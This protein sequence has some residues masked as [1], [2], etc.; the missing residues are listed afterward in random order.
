MGRYDLIRTEFL[1]HAQ[2]L[3]AWA[4]E[5]EDDNKTIK[6]VSRGG[7]NAVGDVRKCYT[8]GKTGLMARE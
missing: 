4:Q 7:Y 5:I 6:S 8:C 3:V 1:H 2:E